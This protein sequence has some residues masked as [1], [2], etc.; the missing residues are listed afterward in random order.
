M[1]KSRIAPRCLNPILAGALAL[2]RFPAFCGALVGGSALL[3]LPIR[4]LILR[5]GRLARA[6]GWNLT[7]QKNDTVPQFLA[8]LAAA[9]L[10]LKLLNSDQKRRSRQWQLTKQDGTYFADL[11]EEQRTILAGPPLAAG[12]E[13]KRVELAGRTMDLTLF[14]VVR[15]VDI[16]VGEA[17]ARRKE[18]RIRAKKWTSAEVSISKFTDAGVFAL[19]ASTVMWA[20]FYQ[21]DRLPRA[22]NKWIGE[23]AQ[24]DSRLIEVLRQAHYGEFVYGKETG[25]AHVLKSMCRD[26]GC[27]EIWGDPAKTVPVPCEIVH[28]G[29]G[30]NCEW[31]AATRFCRAFRFALTTYL[32]LN[33]ALKARS[34]SAKGF[35][36]AFLDAMRSSAFLGAFVSIFYYS[37]CL[38]RTRLGPKMFPKTVTPQMV[39]GGLCVGAG[40]AMCGLSILIEAKRRRQE[41]AFFVAPRAAATFLPRRYD[42]KYQWRETLAFALSAAIVMTCAQEK[43]ERVRGVLGKVLR[44]VLH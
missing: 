20:W 4:V 27:P 33:L 6:Q 28:M 35:Q 3:Q 30:P 39:D 12:F 16:I 15:A 21:P 36:Q 42:E 19:S 31:H 38:S 29:T 24:V 22:Y 23:A 5:V 18:S 26:Y 10:S 14:A 8:A 43:P 40:C 1:G 7:G 17:W 37:I 2:N 44:R 13:I 11:T 25:E 9:W 32:P 34:L 41:I